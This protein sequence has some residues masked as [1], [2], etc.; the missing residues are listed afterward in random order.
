MGPAFKKRPAIVWDE[1]PVTT[2]ALVPPA[3]TVMSDDHDD[4]PSKNTAPPASI[5]NRSDG[6][7]GI[8]ARE[9]GSLEEREARL[10][11]TLKDKKEALG[12][13]GGN[14]DLEKEVARMQR[15][16]FMV[17]VRLS[18]VCF[19]SLFLVQLQQQQE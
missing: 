12:R 13:E 6:G 10:K 3:T 19:Y 14:V 8:I 16:L 9:C 15:E 17:Q 1:L 18:P 11:A 7:G 4:S 5:S 2:A